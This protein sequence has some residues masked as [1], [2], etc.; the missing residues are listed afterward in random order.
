MLSLRPSLSV[1]QSLPGREIPGQQRLLRLW[2]SCVH[3]WQ[4]LTT[5]TVSSAWVTLLP[6]KLHSLKWMF[7]Q[8]LHYIT[9]TKR[10]RQRFA[11]EFLIFAQNHFR[12]NLAQGINQ[13]YQS[14]SVLEIE[15]DDRIRLP[16]WSRSGSNSPTSAPGIAS[17]VRTHW[18]W[19]SSCSLRSIWPRSADI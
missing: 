16:R 17:D 14:Q 11:V 3:C 7:F 1:P 18:I 8:V 15:L 13:F 6:L 9:E 5:Q 4:A 10:T 12:T 19:A 2:R